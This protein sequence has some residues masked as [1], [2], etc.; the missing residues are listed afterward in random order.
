MSLSRRMILAAGAATLAMPAVTRAQPETQTIR[1]GVL[2][3]L[4][5]PYRDITG[6]GSVACAKLAVNEFM[7]AN[8]AIKVELISADH[9]QKPDVGLGIVREWYT[10]SG[11]DVITDVS[12]SAIAIACNTLSAAMDKVSLNVSA[13]SSDLSGKYC[14]TN[15]LS[16]VSDT[17]START[18]ATSEL[19]NNGKTWYFISPDYS[20]G[21]ALVA[22][23]TN[24]VGQG[25]GK[26]VGTSFYPFPG[27]TDY[28][29]FLLAAQQAQAD[30]LAVMSAGDDLVNVVKQAREF[31]VTRGG[32]TRIAACIAT[33]NA[34]A[35]AGLDV[36]QNVTVSELFY[37]D[38]N[39]ATR[40]FTRRVLPLMPNGNYPNSSQSGNYSAVM[41]YLKAVKEIGVEKAKAS[42]RAAIA[43][44]KSIPMDDDVFGPGSIR[45]DQR[46]VHPSYLFRGKA[47]ADSKQ[48]WDVLSLISTVPAE[49]AFRPLSESVCPLVHA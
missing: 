40:A 23:F 10:R 16:W 36:F 3:D 47:Q 48:K 1:I 38:L 30:V 11:V 28:S 32:K 27:T 8:P 44:M 41:H 45:V 43:A 24:F 5:G 25:G 26:V 7:A 2:T 6:G 9:L 14:S 17:Y 34:F 22:D 19:R 20:L 29:S 37:W 13:A 31:G 35:A 21:K 15:A 49:E 46:A 4:S 33:M 42:G 39:D 18:I 12:N